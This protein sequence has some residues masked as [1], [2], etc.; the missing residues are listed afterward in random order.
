M[1]RGELDPATLPRHPQ[2]E[3]QQPMPGI[4]AIVGH[5]V[6]TQSAPQ[7]RRPLPV[8][9]A[10]PPAVVVAPVQD[11]QSGT[12][13]DEYEMVG[14]EGIAQNGKPSLQ[15]SQPFQM[16]YASRPASGEGT[17][18]PLAVL[19][20]PASRNIPKVQR[21]PTRE[22]HM[23]PAEDDLPDHTPS[24]PE[25]ATFPTVAG[26]SRLH[27][28][29]TVVE[30]MPGQRHARDDYATEVEISGDDD[31]GVGVGDISSHASYSISHYGRNKRRNLAAKWKGKSAQKHISSIPAESSEPVAGMPIRPI[32]QSDMTPQLQDIP[33]PSRP[34]LVYNANPPISNHASLTGTP[35]TSGLNLFSGSSQVTPPLPVPQS[36]L[37]ESTVRPGRERRR[38]QEM[39]TLAQHDLE[40]GSGGEVDGKKVRFFDSGSRKTLKDRLL[41]R[42]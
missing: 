21:T 2:E 24:S 19:T 33:A 41:R 36:E 7:A 12:G 16:A 3:P 28:S 27:T 15:I 6:P 20:A 32:T 38:S 18:N 13:E 11:R 4:D 9:P 42:Q 10:A 5:V 22:R 37:S 23:F 39:D 29:E 8:P 30:N 34:T 35:R 17:S 31:E 40:A 1:L 25:G 14:A 26:H